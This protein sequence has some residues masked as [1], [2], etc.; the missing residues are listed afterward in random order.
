M[1]SQHQ[2]FVSFIFVFFY[3]RHLSFISAVSR[4]DFF[5]RY[6]DLFYWLCSFSTLAE[7]NKYEADTRVEFGIGS[8]SQFGSADLKKAVYVNENFRLWAYLV[9]L[10][11]TILEK[12]VFHQFRPADIFARLIFLSP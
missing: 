9:S 1:M 4:V 5:I 2:R 12:L 11:K 8:T 3:L 7:L 6:Y 10:V